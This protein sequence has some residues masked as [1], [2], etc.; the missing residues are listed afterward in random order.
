MT[1]TSAEI[2]FGFLEKLRPGGPWVLTAIKPDG[3]TD[4]IT[5]HN[6]GDVRAF[7]SKNDG[8]KNLYY[9]VNPTRTARTTK[10][11]KLDIAVIEF[12]FVDLD[13]QSHETPEIAKARYLAG[14]KVFTPVPTVIIDSGNGVQALWR[15]S[16]PIMLPEPVV[17]T[18]PKKGEPKRVYLPETQVVIADAEGR[19]KILMER[20]GSVS[21]TQNID[22]ILR[23]PGTSNLPNAKKLKNGRTAC[24]TKVINFNEMIC[25]L[26]EFPS[27][28]SAPDHI[29]NE[30]GA[31]PII[32]M[33]AIDWTIVEQYSGWLK[34]VSD[35]PGKFNLKGKMIVVHGGS[36]DD[37]TFDL[38]QAGLLVKPYRSWSDVSLALAAILKG[39][40]SFSQEQIAAALMCDLECNQHIMHIKDQSAKRRAVERLII[41]S[42]DQAQQSKVKHTA[43]APPWREQGKDGLPRP[44]MHNARLAIIGLAIECTYDTFHNKL[45][46]GYKSDK[47]RHV[48]ETILGEVSD[49]GII[50]LRQLMSDTFGFDLTDKHVRDAVVSLALE[51][52][53][54]P[55]ANM[56]AEAE[57]HWDRV[58]RLD[59][60]AADYLHCTDT[61]LNAAC[62]RKTMIGAVA[63]VRQPGCK[64]DTITVLESPEGFN[65]STAWRV[66]AG[67]DN[68]SDER[69]IGKNSR[70][71][72]EQLSEVWIHENADLAGLKKAEVEEVKTYASRM[73]DIAR[74]AFGHF[75]KKQKRH[76]IDV[77]TTNNSQYLQSQT[78]NRRFWPLVVLKSIDIDL[79]RRDRLQ[80]WG[81]AAH[82]QSA[83]ES[84]VL[85]EALWPAAGVQQEARRVPDPWEDVLAE[86]P[87][88][89][90][91]EFFKD[92]Y[93][94]EETIKI[95][96]TNIGRIGWIGRISP[97][98]AATFRLGL[99][100]MSFAQG[101]IGRALRS[102]PS[103]A[104]APNR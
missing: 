83:G 55:V 53:F 84:L 25:N 6:I 74:P 29:D 46:F 37:L 63:R 38:T 19:V 33:G 3:P 16:E 61:M 40:G 51:H 81:E 17:V 69:I 7:V 90:K 68:F 22:R 101:R 97:T 85:D 103:Q 71:V 21:G 2:A 80:L 14:L 88:E 9:S 60:V 76:A 65:K 82:Y 91:L 99:S 44:S 72:Q 31:K 87:G 26:H 75:L 20:L 45:L 30:A 13:P 8:R 86:I 95:N 66:L 96:L 18:N 94:R 93:K 89:V 24:P 73:T 59:R 52:C 78:G 100:R 77:G 48:V 32:K 10:A 39:H 11:S 15:L 4:T 67:D 28:V 35:L 49:N 42:H 50:A 79:L 27:E 36:L 41:R 57:A 58:A 104:P 92:G 12:S 62:I 47:T 5:A 64:F 23:L 56:L 34:T 102:G 43:N 70:E 54:D 1:K 98:L